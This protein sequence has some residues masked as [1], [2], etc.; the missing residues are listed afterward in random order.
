MKS[1]GARMAVSIIT[2]IRPIVLG[3][4]L[5]VFFAYPVSGALAILWLIGLHLFAFHQRRAGS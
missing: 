3:V 1:R 2:G 5:I 4:F